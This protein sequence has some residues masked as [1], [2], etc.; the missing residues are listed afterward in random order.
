MDENEKKNPE[1]LTREETASMISHELRTSLTA[2]KWMLDMLQDGDVGE[3]TIA[4]KEVVSKLMSSNSRM[5]DVATN[6]IALSK[7]SSHESEYHMGEID[8]VDIIDSVVFELGS[9]AFS[10]HIEIIYVKPGQ[11]I[12]KIHGDESKLRIVFQNLIDN[13]IKYSNSGGRVVISLITESGNL[14]ISIKDTGIGISEKDL[15]M[16]T[17]QFFRAPN[18][19]QKVTA[20]SGI[21]LYICKRIIEGH[22]GTVGIDSKLGEGT[23]ITVTLPI[24]NN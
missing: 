24:P 18:A 23:T 9:E 20:G 16:I 21:G 15:P 2:S 4:Q 7:T 10:Q 12:P 14:R 1:N 6:L 5:M 3:M 17:K 8:V 19:T 13:A 22:S 11:A